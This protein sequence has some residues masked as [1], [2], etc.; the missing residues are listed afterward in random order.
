MVPKGT[1]VATMDAFPH[2]G[3]GNWLGRG[4]SWLQNFY[5][6]NE[7]T[8]NTLMDLGKTIAPLLANDSEEMIDVALMKRRLPALL[9]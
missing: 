9:R 1:D 5:R 3:K 4:I 6:D 7:G 2:A 8:L